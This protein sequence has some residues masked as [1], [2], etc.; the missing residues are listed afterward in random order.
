MTARGRL[1]ADSSAWLSLFCC[2]VTFSHVFSVC[3]CVPY[4][5]SARFYRK[6]CKLHQSCWICSAWP[7]YRRGTAYVPRQLRTYILPSPLPCCGKCSTVRAPHDFRCWVLGMFLAF[8]VVR[9]SGKCLSRCLAAL[10]RRFGLT[11]ACRPCSPRTKDQPRSRSRWGWGNGT[12][13]V[14]M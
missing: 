12:A 13:W 11:P 14:A 9:C 8:V 4:P 1:V 5:G 3:C 2:S 7:R 10:A 6:S